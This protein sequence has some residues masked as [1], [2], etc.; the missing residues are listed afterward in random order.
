MG[1][2][3]TSILSITMITSRSAIFFL[4]HLLFLLPTREVVVAG[5]DDDADEWSICNCPA[6]N[7]NFI[8]DDNDNAPPSAKMAYL[9]SIHNRR[10][11][12]DA[13]Y[14]LKAL[15]E[16]SHPGDTAIIL[17]HIDKRVGI[18]SRDEFHPKDNE[19]EANNNHFLYHDSSL[20][21]YIDA[22]L[23]TPE[24][25]TT[26]KNGVHS[27]G[28]I[29]EVHSRFS[30]EWSKW[31]MNDPTLWAMEYLTYHRSQKQ[32]SSSAWDV[33]VNL[34]GD[35]LPVITAHRISQ[36]FHPTSGPLG[37]TNFVTSSSCLTGLV[38]TSIFTFPK[39]SMKRSHYFQHNIPKTL[40]FVDHITGQ[41][42]D[43]V[44][45][46]I[47]FGSQ[48]MALTSEFVTYAIRSMSHPNGLGNVLK[49]TLI[50]TKVLMTDETFFPTLLMN[51]PY[52]NS[53]VP[54][55]KVEDGSLVQFP[56]LHSLRYE[57]MDENAPNAYNKYT[58]SSSLYDIPPKFGN[59]T[60]GEGP[61]KPW[62]PYFLG[63][64]DL[65]AIRDSGALFVRK[66]SWTVDSNLVRM[67]PVRRMRSS[68]G[69]GSEETE[70]LEWDE[71]P[72]L[73]WPELGVKIH[74]P[75]VWSTEKKKEKS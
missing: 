30:P 39:H 36:L 8:V 66:V 6:S 53:T 46:P 55:V 68:G 34:S 45:T 48:W 35:T 54:Q 9:I 41:W 24:C 28:T 11:I 56:R 16:T 1:G 70:K 26:R 47:Y 72:N 17:L 7:P 44:S 67:L 51:S 74:D 33:F 40:S 15:I 31:S 58:S 22:C 64:Y 38:P 3:S 37:S 20:K 69:S 73:R 57:R 2:L 43:N 65:G 32:Q 14:L 29:L 4:F 62:G 61:A 49:E 75:F 63:V 12:H 25:A 50:Q 5:T 60:D 59:V 27:N 10:T 23:A 19:D 21:R 18:A 52:F 71:L 42:K 13:A